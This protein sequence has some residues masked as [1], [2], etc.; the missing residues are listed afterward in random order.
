MPARSNPKQSLFGSTIAERQGNPGELQMSLPSAFGTQETQFFYE[1]TPERIL[2]AVESLGFRCTGRCLQ[3]NSMENRVYEI[4]VE[5]EDE[6]LSPSSRERFRIAKFYRPG[7]WS[8]EQITEE[9][10]FLA[11]IAAQEIP[12]ITPYQDASGE[13]LFELPDTGI[14]YSLFPKA[15]GRNP[16]EL[17]DAQ[18]LQVGR[19]LGRM[20]AAGCL[21][22]AP[23]RLTMIPED[24]T[25]PSLDFLLDGQ[26]LPE[27]LEDQYAD[28]VESIVELS[29]PLFAGVPLQR[30]HGDAHLG[31][32]LWGAEGAF[33]V[34]FDDMVMGPC[35]QDLWLIVPGRDEY[36][37]AKLKIVLEGYEQ[38]RSFDR[39][40]LRLIEPLRAMRIIHFN[41]WIAKRWDDPAFQRTFVEFG[42]ERYWTEQIQTL[43]EQEDLIGNIH[44]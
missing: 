36:A 42:T 7:R 5:V 23:S 13:T 6:S 29:S 15:G 14:L 17:D 34:D 3:L 32:L 8:R 9:H 2:A 38:F 27:F 44:A 20:H 10:R 25:L 40:T 4:E 19:L 1:L 18:S 43:R 30:I 35:V 37:Q 39:K 16:D 11:D 12:T 31:N 41:A 28:L 24:F 21:S 26:F 22:P 33:W